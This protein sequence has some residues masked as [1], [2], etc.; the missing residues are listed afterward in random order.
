MNIFG[1]N[2]MKILMIFLGHHKIGLVLGGKGRHSVCGLSLRRVNKSISRTWFINKHANY[3]ITS[4][5]Y[6]TRLRSRSAL[7]IDK[8]TF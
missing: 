6:P 1:G 2:F 3:R 5:L 4:E 8:E 7:L